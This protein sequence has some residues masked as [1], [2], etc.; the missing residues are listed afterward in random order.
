MADFR[1]QVNQLRQMTEQLFAEL[2]RS[3][4]NS[5]LQQQTIK[6]QQREIRALRAQVAESQKGQEEKTEPG[7]EK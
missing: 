7:A 2:G 1:E 5:I 3:Y 4:F 6:D